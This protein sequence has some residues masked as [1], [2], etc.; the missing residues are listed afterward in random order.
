MLVARAP[1]RTSGAAN[2]SARS[3][4]FIVPGPVGGSTD[5]ICRVVADKLRGALGKAVA[6]ENRS[7][8]GSIGATTQP[9]GHTLHSGCADRSQ[10]SLQSQFAL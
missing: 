4:T 5:T 3:I 7:G 1:A 10:L 2:Y 8:G 9:D 6:V